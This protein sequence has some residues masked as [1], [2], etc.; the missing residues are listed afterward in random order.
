M[1]CTCPT[2]GHQF[3]HDPFADLADQPLRKN[4]HEPWIRC[5]KCNE[6][7]VFFTRVSDPTKWLVP[8]TRPVVKIQTIIAQLQTDL[9]S[10]LGTVETRTYWQSRLE[11]LELLIARFG[12]VELCAEC[13]QIIPDSGGDHVQKPKG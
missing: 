1:I 11:E 5:P 3:E 7:I 8:E 9:A 12:D 2:C 13:G 10:D 6:P 4:I